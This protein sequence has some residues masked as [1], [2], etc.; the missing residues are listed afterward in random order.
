MGKTKRGVTKDQI[1]PKHNSAD[2]ARVLSEA[3]LKNEMNANKVNAIAKS[4]TIIFVLLSKRDGKAKVI[5]K[6]GRRAKN[7]AELLQFE[8]FAEKPL[9][10]E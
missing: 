10:G 1:Y 6:T 4:I 8:K 3:F 2:R 7:R 9:I 5:N